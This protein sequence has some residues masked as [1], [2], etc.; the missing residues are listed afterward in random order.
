M[1]VRIRVGHVKVSAIADDRGV[2]KIAVEKDSRFASPGGH[3]FRRSRSRPPSLGPRPSCGPNCNTAESASI[4]V[5]AL[6]L[7]R[8]GC[9]QGLFCDIHIRD[10]MTAQIRSHETAVIP[11]WRAHSR[12]TIFQKR[13]QPGVRFVKNQESAPPSQAKTGHH[14]FRISAFSHRTNHLARFRTAA[15]TAGKR[16]S[17]RARSRSGIYTAIRTAR[18]LPR[19]AHQ[20][21]KK[22]R[23]PKRAPTRLLLQSPPPPRRRPQRTPPTARKLALRLP[24]RHL[25]RRPTRPR[26]R[27]HGRRFREGMQLQRAQERAAAIETKRAQAL[28]Q[29]KADKPRPSTKSIPKIQPSTLPSSP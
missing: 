20:R 16:N 1:R 2:R 10:R 26:N 29:P 15:R 9:T 27:L 24:R 13:T 5:A 14:R 3:R 28:T 4:H 19:S 12:R 11:P 6:Y 8:R 17:P 7:A 18:P 21:R 23:Q 25:H 22:T